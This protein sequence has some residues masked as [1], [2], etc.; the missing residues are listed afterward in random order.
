MDEIFYNKFNY[1]ELIFFFISCFF[2]TIFLIKLII[3]V[4]F[5][6]GLVDKQDNRK[7][8]KHSV[9]RLGG[10]GFSTAVILTLLVINCLYEFGFKYEA[11]FLGAISLV[12]LID[13]VFSLKA[14]YKFIFQIIISFFFINNFF[15]PGLVG[16][17]FAGLF[18]V[19]ITNSINLID[20]LDGLAGG[21]TSIAFIFFTICGVYLNDQYMFILSFISLSSMLAFLIYNINPA[22]IFMGDCGS[23]FLGFLL[24]L[25]SI[26]LMIALPGIRGGIASIFVL[27][28]P[29]FD[30]AIT[31]VR[32]FLS[33]QPLF[34]PD[35][36]HFHHCLLNKGFS[37]SSSAFILNA[38]SFLFTCLALS[39]VIFNNAFL[40][41]LPILIMSMGFFVNY[42]KILNR[43][44][45]FNYVL[46][47][48]R[49]L[50]R[51]SSK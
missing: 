47:S 26:R 45:F 34:Y 28:I 21:I 40:F 18:I 33:G 50:V 15:N 43:S 2:F 49:R 10:V 3:L 23:L 19:Y 42:L 22:K 36:E 24:S 20:G 25:L 39:I 4:S 13:D 35:K 7:I 44:S 1:N 16:V 14:R 29:V 27:T 32:R 37:H 8:H 41:A 31:I 11:F 9:S 6:I 48:T 12:G 30:T 5:K 51:L 17:F 38:L 46:F